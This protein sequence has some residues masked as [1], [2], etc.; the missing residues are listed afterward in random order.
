MV[1]K[2]AKPKSKTPTA[3]EMFWRSVTAF[4]EKE[5]IDLGKGL[6]PSP[7]ISWKLEIDV[8]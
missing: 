8:I 5:V 6:C 3:L 1:E 4:G 2:I 7:Y